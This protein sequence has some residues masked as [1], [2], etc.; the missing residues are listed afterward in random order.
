M[1][2]N[3]HQTDF[4]NG[5]SALGTLTVPDVAEALDFF[6]QRLGFRVEMILP[7]DDPHVVVVSGQGLT[8]RLE[9]RQRLATPVAAT[10]ETNEGAADLLVSRLESNAGWHTGR[11]GMQYR[12]L[13]PGRL[14]GRVIAS[15]IRIP[16][17]GLVPDYVHYHKVQFQM[18]FCK[19]GWVRVVYE[20]QGPP[21]VLQAGDCVLQP[22]EIRHRV[23]EASPG[24]EVIEVGCPASHETH[25]DHQLP[26]PTSQVLPERV[27]NGQRF[28]RHVASEAVWQPWRLDGFESRDLGIEAA[29]NGLAVVQVIRSL[30]GVWQSV[31]PAEAGVTQFWFVLQGALTLQHPAEGVQKLQAGDSCVFPAS[32]EFTWQ[33]SPDLEWL[34]VRLAA[35]MPVA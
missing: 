11:A 6:T 30:P 3:Q 21:F 24:L 22:P 17:G 8:L 7:A 27:F 33:P 29:T 4:S 28:V 5:P 16:D 32:R 1:Q 23:L 19:A 13:I 14:G 18:I 10:L 12:D 31:V 20:D 25:A 9:A 34:E 26:L 2:D 15:Q 35:E